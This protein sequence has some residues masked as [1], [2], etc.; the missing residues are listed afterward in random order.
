MFGTRLGF[1]GTPSSLLPVDLGAC[2][3][4]PGSQGRMV[5]VLS[6]PTV[7]VAF[8]ETQCSPE[9]FLVEVAH[10]TPTPLALI[11]VG[12]LVTGVTNKAAAR[13]LLQHLPPRLKG[14]VYLDAAGRQ[15]IV[16]RSAPDAPIPLSQCGLDRTE[17][18]TFYD[19]VHTTGI[20][21]KQGLN[22]SA[23]VTVGK[24]TTLRDYAQGCWR[25]RGLG[26]GQTV[27][28]VF[29]KEVARLVQDSRRP[30]VC[31][32]GAPL[33]LGDVLGWLV[34]NA[35]RVE[36]LQSVALSIQVCVGKPWWRCLSMWLPGCGAVSMMVVACVNDGCGC[37]FF[38]L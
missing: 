34:V 7:C 26:K 20:D 22:A 37:L 32:S 33:Q 27:R 11:D 12:A 4:E 23:V 38:T 18:F 36:S 16:L 24:D 6:D 19:Q 10:T 3:F 15:V 25:M 35:M 31:A 13:V 2:H 9:E 29:R 21:I 14:V 28:L 30:E 8:G 17:R 1:S 5:G